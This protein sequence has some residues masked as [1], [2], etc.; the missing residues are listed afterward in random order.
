MS[1]WG[2]G[3]VTDTAYVLD[4]CRVQT[5]PVLAMAAL[6]AGVELPAAG[7]RFRYCD[8]GCGQ[9]FTANLIA[10]AN[11]A[12]QVIGYDFNP[13]HIAGARAFAEEAKIGNVAFDEAS[14]DELAAGRD[15]PSFDVIAA[16]GVFS[17]ISQE[18]RRALVAFVAKRLKPGGLFYIS[19]NAMPGWAAFVPLRRLFARHYA[20]RPGL[21]SPQAVERALAYAESLR[22][23]E[24][25]YFKMFPNVERQ[26]DRL[27]GSPGAYFAH[28]LLNRNWEAFCF[29][30][31]A[32]A[33]ADAKLTYL[34]PSYL[35]DGVDRINFSEKQLATL[36]TID[37][38]ILAEET[39]D[40]FASRQ[41]RRDVFVK[42]K[43]AMG[44]RRERA[45][46]LDQR[47]VLTVP[48]DEFDLTFETALG[49]MQLRE[50]I[51]GPLIEALREGPT[52]LRTVLARHPKA[53][54]HWASLV[55][56]V[57]ILVARGDVSPALSEEGAAA[58]GASVRAF[59]DAVLA[60]A[61]E[62]GDLR[63]LASP[64]TGGGVPVD[65]LA[66]LY[67]LAKRRGL[68]E[69]A[70]EIATLAQAGAP[71]D[72]DGAPPTPEVA[73][74]FGVEQAKRVETKIAPLLARLGID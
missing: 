73:R 18:N 12:A 36:A 42:G 44:A 58:R 68:P 20:P 40:M 62:R 25:R 60:R 47:F 43:V 27:K 16:H 11:P 33:L 2:S 61:V 53:A 32:E 35:L 52:S 29:G 37:D 72:K 15:G 69:P 63:H 5:P 3:Y 19:Y 31:V 13:G 7:E 39:R 51:H 34:G 26:W 17:W 57:K 6:A 46:W 54:E 10:A 48:P 8:L 59:N 50:E 9:G 22:Q 64:V 67:L 4:Y 24:A 49:K 14:F 71:N 65:R 66:Q 55:D 28:E 70:T 74:A 56:A 38:P 30:E 41:F 21:A 23:A 45:L 1:D